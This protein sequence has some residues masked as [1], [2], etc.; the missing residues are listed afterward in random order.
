MFYQIL[1]HHKWTNVQ[2]LLINRIYEFPQELS[3]NLRLRKLGNIRKVS[4]LH[5]MIGYCPVFQQEWKLCYYYQKTSKNLQLNF[6]C[7]VLFHVQPQ[8]FSD[9][10]WKP[11]FDSNLPQTPS[12]L[13]SLTIFISLRSFT[14][15]Y[16]KLEQ[17]SCKKGQKFALLF[18]VLPNFP[19]TP[20][21]AM[22]NYYL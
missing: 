4:N 11:F 10:L 1:F 15:F 22:P 18:D 21:G 8:I 13:N 2:L 7:S 14:L 17:L 9:C 16:I 6:S 5:R 12:N 19:C 20:S 3:N